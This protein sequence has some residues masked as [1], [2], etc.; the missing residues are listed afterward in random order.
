MQ[1]IFIL[2]SCLLGSYWF[3]Y[4]FPQV[5]DHAVMKILTFQVNKCLGIIR[6]II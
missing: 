2:L 4:V 6:I 5:A 1:L 3:L